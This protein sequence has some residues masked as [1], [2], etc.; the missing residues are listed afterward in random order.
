VLKQDS[1]L[2]SGHCRR[3]TK[4]RAIG[5]SFLP[6]SARP[7]PGPVKSPEWPTGSSRIETVVAENAKRVLLVDGNADA[8]DQLREAV[9]AL[10]HEAVV[11]WSGLA[12][13]TAAVDFHAHVAFVDLEMDNGYETVAQLCKMPHWEKARFLPIRQPLDLEEIEAALL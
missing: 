10:G 1:Q 9:E 4:T 5:S 6:S 3:R 2:L 8:A 11:V 12:A 7:Q 13:L